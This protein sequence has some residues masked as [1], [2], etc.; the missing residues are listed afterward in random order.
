MKKLV[1]MI[2][3]IMG[4]FISMTACAQKKTAKSDGADKVAEHKTLVAYFSVTGTTENVAKTIAQA[5]NA[6][7]LKIEPKQEYTATDLDWR[8]ENSRSSQEMK[9]PKARPEINKAKDNLDEY[10][11]VYLG[12]PIW[13][14]LAPRIVNS[15]IEAY[16]LKG[17]TVIPF[18][19]SGGSDIDNA[20]NTLKSEYPEINWQQGKL[21]NGSSK[22]DIE[23]WTKSN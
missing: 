20:A 21:L 18:A 10:D 22:Q 11:V 6:E 12:F 17:K 8:N 23:N 4:I 19:T 9:N 7:L 1:F 14:N 13:W 5:A 2:A 16:S 15:F 3:A